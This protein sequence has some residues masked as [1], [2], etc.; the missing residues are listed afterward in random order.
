M[1]EKRIKPDFHFVQNHKI[2]DKTRNRQTRF[3]EKRKANLTGY[4]LCFMIFS[5]C[6]L[7]SNLYSP[8][9][10]TSDSISVC[11]TAGLKK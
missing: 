6:S 10:P 7:F 4:F 2:N 1:R 3:G 8:A 5:G 11:S 9:K